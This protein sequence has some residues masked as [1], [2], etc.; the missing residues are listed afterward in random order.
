MLTDLLNQAAASI[1]AAPTLCAA[2]PHYDHARRMYQL[3]QRMEEASGISMPYPAIAAWG[4]V[5]V[6]FNPLVI[7]HSNRVGM[8]F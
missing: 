2:Q 3:T 7:R 6:A 5:L 1:T 8:T 4:R